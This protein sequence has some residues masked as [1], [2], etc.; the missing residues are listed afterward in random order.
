MT[1]STL[2]ASRRVRF[3]E[4]APT[5]TIVA[6]FKAQLPAL[7]ADKNLPIFP[8][9]DDL[10]DIQFAFVTLPSGHTVVVGQYEN[11]PEVG[12]DLHIDL[13]NQNN[14]NAIADL[15]VETCQY[16]A[17]PRSNVVWFHP[18]YEAEIDRSYP[19]TSEIIRQSELSQSQELPPIDKYEPLDCF[20]H[21]LEIY[22][23][24]KVP[25]YWAMLQHNLGLAYY[26]RSKGERW[27]NLRTSIECFNKSLEVFT[28]AEFHQKWQ[29]NQEDMIQSQQALQKCRVGTAHSSIFL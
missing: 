28:Q 10:D 1:N 19:S 15:V 14:V 23:R 5:N 27:E 17:I 24:E 16:L 12:V 13:R 3:E 26:H 7:V 21:A 29:I 8:G 9:Y 6:Y 25:E 22:T 11:A 2:R 20:Y 4:V 18:D